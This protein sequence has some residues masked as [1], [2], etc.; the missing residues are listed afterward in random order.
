MEEKLKDCDCLAKTQIT[1]PSI[2]S[3]RTLLDLTN[4]LERRMKEALNDLRFTR[5]GSCFR[6]ELDEDEFGT[7]HYY[8]SYFLCTDKFL[9]L[10]SPNA[11]KE[12]DNDCQNLEADLADQELKIWR[13]Q[14]VIE[15]YKTKL[16]PCLKDLSKKH[17]DHVQDAEEI[18]QKLLKVVAGNVEKIKEMNRLMKKVREENCACKK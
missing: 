13:S 1:D 9:E 4:S 7:P 14:E 17:K 16:I 8:S 10:Y 18:A 2:D 15:A 12:E 5:S 3:Y 11:F 6:F